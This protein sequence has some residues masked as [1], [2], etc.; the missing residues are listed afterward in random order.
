MIRS[1]Y[2][3]KPKLWDSALS[4]AKFAYNSSVHRT[5]WKAP[6]AI[7]YTKIPRQAVDLV[8]L[9]GGQGV[10]VAA[11]HMA[12]NWQTMTEEVKDKIE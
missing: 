12:E 4:H 8:K 1:I 3:D 5:T 2:G 6:F 11:K 7:V 10:S 9:P